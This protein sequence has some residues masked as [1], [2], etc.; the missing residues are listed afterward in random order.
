MYKQ[1]NSRAVNARLRNFQYDRI[2]ATDLLALRRVLPG[3]RTC[4]VRGN[5]VRETSVK[6]RNE[7]EQEIM[8][9]VAKFSVF[10]Q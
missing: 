1:G 3:P 7:I 8:R 6:K 4:I 10:T 2:G 9:N 5:C